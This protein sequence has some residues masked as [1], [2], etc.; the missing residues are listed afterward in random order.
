[1]GLLDASNTADGESV[2]A[3]QE[4]RRC[5]AALRRFFD[6]ALTRSGVD[7]A[8]RRC[9][10]RHQRM[11]PEFQFSQ[12]SRSRTSSSVSV[13]LS[14]LKDDTIYS[15]SQ[16]TTASMTASSSSLP[17]LQLSDDTGRTYQPASSRVSSLLGRGSHGLSPVDRK[18]QDSLSELILAPKINSLEVARSQCSTVSG[19]SSILL[20]LISTSFLFVSVIAI[21]F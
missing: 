10:N 11:R 20:L 19:D 17:K 14:F 9:V 4:A 6:P 3:K 13:P 1:M 15:S 21:V 12:R 18:Q 2:A 7:D 16:V 5:L 8:L